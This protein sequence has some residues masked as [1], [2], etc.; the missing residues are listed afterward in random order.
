MKGTT[1]D[2]VAEEA[3]M[4]RGHIRHY[5]GNRDEMIVDA[6]KVLFFD[7]VAANAAS[8]NEIDPCAG[9]ASLKMTVLELLDYLFGNFA[10]TGDENYAASAFIG[11]RWLEQ[12]RSR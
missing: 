3:S 1:L 7:D 4:A 9:N 5:V 10:E 2:R 6:A 8:V 12:T 11:A